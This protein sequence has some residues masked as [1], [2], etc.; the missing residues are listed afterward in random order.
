MRT[1]QDILPTF[2]G[3]GVRDSYFS[4]TTQSYKSLCVIHK[5]FLSVVFNLLYASDTFAQHL[6]YI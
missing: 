2:L 1:P 3:I 5:I 4:K 6:K